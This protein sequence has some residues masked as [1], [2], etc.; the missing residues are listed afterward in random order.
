MIDCIAIIEDKEETRPWPY[1]KNFEK[2]FF[3]GGYK[4][5]FELQTKIWKAGSSITCYQEVKGK[6]KFQQLGSDPVE[7]NKGSRL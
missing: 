7:A 1:L 3:V 2:S 6:E 4:V 5:V